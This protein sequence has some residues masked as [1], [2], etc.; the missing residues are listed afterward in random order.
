MP[1]RQCSATLSLLAS[2][3]LA[4]ATSESGWLSQCLSGVYVAL[5]ALPAAF[6]LNLR[7][8]TTLKEKSNG[9]FF[10]PIGLGIFYVAPPSLVLTEPQS[11]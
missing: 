5:F 7:A 2:V 4:V 8:E 6:W 1:A 11:L 9:V 3:V 10:A